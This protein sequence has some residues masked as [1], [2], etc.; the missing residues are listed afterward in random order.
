MP[1][2]RGGRCP[3]IPPE[4]SPFLRWTRLGRAAPLDRLQKGSPCGYRLLLTAD[5]PILRRLTVRLHR[6]ADPARRLSPCVETFCA[7]HTASVY[8]C[9]CLQ[10]GKKPSYPWGAPAP[11]H[12]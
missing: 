9:D 10:R 2:N 8:E 5:I 3:T 11:H 6:F 7:A 1:E 12:S 4:S